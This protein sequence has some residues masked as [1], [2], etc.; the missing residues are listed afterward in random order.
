M[1]VKINK[2]PKS[3]IELEI[4]VSAE[5][6]DRFIEKACFNLG[7]NLEIKGFRKGKAPKEFIEKEIGKEKILIEAANL[8]V[9][10]NY[11]KAVLENKIE[12]VFQPK[13]EIKKLALGNPFIFSAKTAVLP[14]VSL[15]DYKKIA[16]KV[17]R[18]EISVEDKEV[19]PALK[20]LQKS[21]AKFS[22][23]NQPAQKGD[24]VE[25]EYN[26][27]RNKDKEL[28]SLSLKEPSS[29]KDAFILGEGHFLQGFEEKII[30]MKS[31]EEKE[32]ITLNKDGKDIVLKVKIISVQNV[33]FPELND[34][35]AKSAAKFD[36]LDALKKNIKQGL[37][38]EKEQAEKQRL[39]QE[40]L[41]RIGEKAKI[42]IPDV[43]IENEQKQMLENLKKIVSERLNPVRDSEGREKAQKEGISNGV[44]ISFHDYLKKLGKTEEQVSDS[45]LLESQ[46]KVRNYL[47]LREISKKE[48]DSEEIKK[49][50]TE[51]EKIE[52]I[53]QL[54]EEL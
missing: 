15:P 49:Y 42:E 19:E 1:R 22:A 3:Q 30:G 20:W 50:T 52:K 17:E 28:G 9:E 14:E 8:A 48:L 51:S 35:F 24:F 16:S 47:I 26:L 44:K 21:R 32:N 46:K 12:A 53:F 43:L 7:R 5:E 37:V 33:E 45:F 31:G 13:I 2:L 39:R 10:E 40:I 41:E 54:L 34:E 11:R 4:E 27:S 23:K 36:N 29:L 6:L 38:L 25:I 18:K